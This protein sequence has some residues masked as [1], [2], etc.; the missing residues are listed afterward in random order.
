MGNK[1]TKNKIYFF[2]INRS[3]EGNKYTYYFA[4]ALNRQYNVINLDERKNAIAVFI[5][6]STFILNWTENVAFSPR[7]RVIKSIVYILALALLKICRKKVIWIFHNK[8]PHKGSNLLSKLL[9]TYNAFMSDLI[10]T[11]S[12][13]GV[14]YC[15][16]HYYKKANIFH[17]PHPV[18]SE[19]TLV[20]C[21]ELY[22][23]IIWGE[24]Q[25]HKRIL[26]FLKFWIHMDVSKEYKLLICGRCKDVWYDDSIKSRL[27]PNITYMNRYVNTDELNKMISASKNILF[28]YND[29]SILSSGSLAYSLPFKKHIIGPNKGQFADYREIGLIDTY[30]DFPEIVKLLRQTPHIPESTFKDFTDNYTWDKFIDV[31]N[32]KLI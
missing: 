8:H 30:N 28:T 23:I 10:I 19:A 1:K 21:S 29:D 26:E 13:E 3:L 18:Y 25:A 27:I 7:K 32:Q 2:P 15:K 20:E 22:D 31:I 24:I 17:F 4:E 14:L 11:H 5:K 6:A 12:K 16:N 9:M